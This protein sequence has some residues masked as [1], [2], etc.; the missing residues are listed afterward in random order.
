MVGE[1]EGMV[2]EVEMEDVLAM[3]GEVADMIGRN[4]FGRHLTQ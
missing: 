1:V 3:A 4:T 2:G